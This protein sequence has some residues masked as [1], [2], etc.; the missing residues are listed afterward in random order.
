M[1]KHLG[2]ESKRGLLVVTLV[3]IAALGPYLTA[4]VR[5]EQ[6]VVYGAGAILIPITLPL[7]RTRGAMLSVTV[8]WVLYVLGVVF[9][10]VLP[11]AELTPLPSGGGVL[12]GLDNAILPFVVILIVLGL[13]VLGGDPQRLLRRV[14][15]WIV[16]LMCLNAAAAI[17]QFQG[18]YDFSAWYGSEGL[19]SVSGRAAQLGRYGGLINQPAEAGALYSIAGLCAVYR[20]RHRPVLLVLALAALVSGGVLTVSKVFLLGGL[21]LVLIAL[22]RGGANRAS[23]LFAMV[24][25]AFA[26]WVAVSAELLPE[27]TGADRIR[28]LL[29]TGSESWVE[30]FTASRYGG[31]SGGT[32]GQVVDAVMSGPWAFGYGASGLQVPYDSGW[33]EALVV[34]GVF[35][36]AVQALVFVALGRGWARMPRCPERTL[37][38]YL[39]LILVGASL[40]LPALT[41]NRVA[42]V[43]WILLAL[44]LA[45]ATHRRTRADQTADAGSTAATV[46]L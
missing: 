6:V 15:G 31:A 8:L 37:L 18:L 29:P 27:W 12:A 23:R 46:E 17:M 16:L 21:P 9:S 32:T 42:T 34:A 30:V 4:G 38:G 5:A 10:T 43:A 36:V 20:L 45:C 2:A 40:G 33:V 19:E 1:Q 7:V 39:V 28:G 13:T 26:G 44:L 25:V 24:A 22:L 14:T 35:G 11:S 41:A 3:L